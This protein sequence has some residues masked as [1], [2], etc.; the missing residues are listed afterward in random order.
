MCVII[1]RPCQLTEFFRPTVHSLMFV[2]I[3]KE[4]NVNLRIKTESFEV[5]FCI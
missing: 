4:E 1:G 5:V 3:T 2:V